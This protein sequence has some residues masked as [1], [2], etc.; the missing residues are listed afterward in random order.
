[1]AGESWGK[2]EYNYS[3]EKEAESIMSEG[4]T[5]NEILL[6][7][8]TAV[9]PYVELRGAIPMALCMGARPE[10]AFFLGVAGNLMPI[11]PIMLVLSFLARWSHRYNYF[12]HLMKWIQMKSTKQQEKINRYGYLRL[13]L[14][15]AIPLPMSGVWTGAAVAYLLGI[16]KRIAIPALALG[17]VI[18]GI[19][20]TL[21]TI[22]VL[23]IWQ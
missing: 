5:L 6:I 2:E 1:M 20:V 15:V 4:L 22:G 23:T 21:A 9:L 8:F 16:K 12:Y 11:I 7:L 10:E 14:F 18:A 13:M 17:T 3:Y 19:V